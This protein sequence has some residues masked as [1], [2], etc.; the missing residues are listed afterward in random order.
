MLSPGFVRG[1]PR[2]SG[3][4][5]VVLSFVRFS[6]CFDPALQTY[7]RFQPSLG[8]MGPLLAILLLRAE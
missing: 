1:C 6:N 3:S 4:I 2:D 8:R 5:V 7:F